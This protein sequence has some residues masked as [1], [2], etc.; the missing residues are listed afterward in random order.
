[1]S[2]CTFDRLKVTEKKIQPLINQKWYID[3]FCGGKLFCK[4]NWQLSCL[5][6]GS[7]QMPGS[8]LAPTYLHAIICGN[9]PLAGPHMPPHWQT[10][11]HWMSHWQPFHI[12]PK[13]RTPNS[14]QPHRASS[15]RG[16]SA[17]YS[18]NS[19]MTL[20]TGPPLPA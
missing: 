8:Y 20:F 18:L 3:F 19:T 10:Y 2:S 9:Q 15:P 7:A 1:M 16:C 14:A 13:P 5:F 11:S 12:A 4:K 6:M 17:D